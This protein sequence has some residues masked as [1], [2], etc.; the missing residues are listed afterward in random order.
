MRA[1]RRAGCAL[2]FYGSWLMLLVQRLLGR[3]QS[4]P[5]SGIGLGARYYNRAI[6]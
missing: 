1:G 4:G 2:L 3:Q 5:Q 6:M